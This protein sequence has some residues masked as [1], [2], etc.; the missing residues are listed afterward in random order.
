MSSVGQRLQAV[1]TGVDTGPLPEWLEEA[2]CG[3]AVK[4]LAHLA[5]HTAASGGSEA[6]W[7]SWVDHNV[8]EASDELMGEASECMHGAGLW[9]WP[10]PPEAGGDSACWAQRVCPACGRLSDAESPVACE[11]CG[12][13]FDT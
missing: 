10:A 1:H 9:P 5:L 3:P 6:D 7:R 12:A 2:S 11:A 13:S 8:P 4:H